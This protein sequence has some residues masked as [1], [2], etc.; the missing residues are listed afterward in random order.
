MS[1]YEIARSDYL[2]TGILGMGVGIVI[3]IF[4]VICLGVFMKEH[5]P[6]H[7]DFHGYEGKQK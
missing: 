5:E 7:H 6:T 1:C 4:G 2:F 3:S